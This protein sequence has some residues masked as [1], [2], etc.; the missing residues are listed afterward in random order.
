MDVQGCSGAGL[1]EPVVNV[2][3][4]DDATT[5]LAGANNTAN[6]AD[7]YVSGWSTEPPPDETILVVTV[8]TTNPLKD[9][10]VNS[11]FSISVTC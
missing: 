8:D 4:D 6:V 10:D 1:A 5:T 11:D 9:I 7:A 3:A 2:T